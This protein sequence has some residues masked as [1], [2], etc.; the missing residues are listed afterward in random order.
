MRKC[1]IE[2]CNSKVTLIGACSY[3]SLSFCN[4]H[5]LP[6]KHECKKINEISVIK[7]NILVKNLFENS[8]K[9]KK[10]NSI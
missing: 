7:R 5:R 1:F 9:V 6:E 4:K 10:F 3:C 8:C 2:V